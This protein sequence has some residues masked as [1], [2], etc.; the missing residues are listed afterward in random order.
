MVEE[1]KSEMAEVT[2]L[3]R[4]D[5]VKGKVTKVENNQVMVDVNYKF[6]GVIP[7]SVLSSLLVVNCFVFV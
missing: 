6:D 5:I 4:G 2:P 7:I 1:M 3:N